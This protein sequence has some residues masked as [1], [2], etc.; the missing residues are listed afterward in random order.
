MSRALRLWVTYC[1]C[2]LVFP[3]QLREIAPALF[4]TALRN[5]Q[6]SKTLTHSLKRRDDDSFLEED[7]PLTVLGAQESRKTLI[8]F[9]EVYS[10][11]ALNFFF[12]LNKSRTS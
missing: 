4:Y 12:P 1:K 10:K 9:F 7:F 6:Y 5:A 2:A 11:F 3:P 8:R